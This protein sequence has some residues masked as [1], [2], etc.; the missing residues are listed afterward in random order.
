MKKII[1]IFFIFIFINFYIFKLDVISKNGEDL[2]EEILPIRDRKGNFK[3]IVCNITLPK[4]FKEKTITVKPDI[5]GGIN[6]FRKIG[7]GKSIIRL[8]INNKSKY[9]YKYVSNSF[10]ISTK[11]LDDKNNYINTGGKGFDEL[12]VFYIFA[13]YRVV[14]SALKELKI[15]NYTN[16]TIDLKLKELGYVGEEELD[17]YYR[18]F[19]NKK[20]NLNYKDLDDFSASIKKEIFTGEKLD[21]MEKNKNIIILAYNYFYNYVLTFSMNNKT[22]SIGSYMK[23]EALNKFVDIKKKSQVNIKNMS[24][25]IEKSYMTEAFQNFNYLGEVKFKLNRS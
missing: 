11:K 8:N 23:G 25:N 13:P 24:L 14:N 22:K 10:S 12:D 3:G 16:Q 6:E 4:N 5:F 2:V 1:F 20:F 9:K 19:Y 21:Y 17:T 7:E 18:D 15:N